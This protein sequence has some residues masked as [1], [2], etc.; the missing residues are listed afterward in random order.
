MASRVVGIGHLP[1]HPTK[2]GERR[3]HSYPKNVRCDLSATIQSV[4]VTWDD[5]RGHGSAA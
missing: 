1:S 2:E 3:E 5:E 4:P